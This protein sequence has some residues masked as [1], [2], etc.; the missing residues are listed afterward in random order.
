M[1]VLSAALFSEL[2]DVLRRP[3]LQAALGLTDEHAERF[4][5]ALE[6]AADFVDTSGIP[7]V[8]I[9]HVPKDVDVVLTAIAGQAEVICT[10]DRH[11]MQPQ[12]IALC[13]TRGIR[14]MSDID[15]LLALR[16][17]GQL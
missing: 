4:L 13:K 6:G 2:A 1:V 3:R 5:R 17:G 12:V 7:P 10:R 11:L 15:L 8:E 16:Q 9:P 14:V